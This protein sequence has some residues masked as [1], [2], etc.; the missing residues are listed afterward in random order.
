MKLPTIPSDYNELIPLHQL[1]DVTG[2]ATSIHSKMLIAW[3]NYLVKVV[4]HIGFNAEADRVMRIIMNTIYI[5][6]DFEY[7]RELILKFQ[8]VFK[9][10]IIPDGEYD[11]KLQHVLKLMDCIDCETIH[12][13][14]PPTVEA[15]NWIRQYMICNEHLF[16]PNI[17]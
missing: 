4:N 9:Y 17:T 12:S 15:L 10:L 14:N 3:V 1:A 2:N 11:Q 13:E 6:S 7:A 5:D 8:D 16:I